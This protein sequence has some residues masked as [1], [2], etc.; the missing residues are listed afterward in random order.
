MDFATASSV[1]IGTNQQKAILNHQAL[2][3]F[4]GVKGGNKVSIKA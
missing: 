1:Y 4:V 2:V 3:V